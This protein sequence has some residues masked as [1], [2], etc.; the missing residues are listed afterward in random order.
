MYY[1]NGALRYMSSSYQ[2]LPVDYIWLWSCFVICLLIYNFSL[3]PSLYL[4]VSWAWWDWP[5]TW[6]TNYCPSVLWQWHC[7]L[8]HVTRKIVSEM[9]Y[10]VSSGTLNSTIFYNTIPYHTI[11]LRESSVAD[12]SCPFGHFVSIWT[13]RVHFGGDRPTSRPYRQGSGK[14]VMSC[15]DQLVDIYISLGLVKH[16]GDQ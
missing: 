15:T 7:W 3:H 4:L 5:L 8:G 12:T 1:Y 9:T 14:C 10:N 16:T 11:L 13:L 6:L 2:F